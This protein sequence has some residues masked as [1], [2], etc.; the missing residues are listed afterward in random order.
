MLKLLLLLEQRQLDEGKDLKEQFRLTYDSLRP[1][2]ILISAFKD[3]GTSN[4]LKDNV[5]NSTVGL[6]A[7]Y[8][9]K[10]LFQG[11]IGSPLKK[12]LGSALMFSV[13][14]LVSKNPDIIKSI[15]KHIF[16]MFKNKSES[17]SE[18]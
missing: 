10:I 13:Q 8:V 5:L 6:G 18:S 15:G 11:I 16:K 1:A 3:L 2:N 7:C 4:D 17:E 14:N 9:S 12:L